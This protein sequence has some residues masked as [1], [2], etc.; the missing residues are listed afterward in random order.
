MTDPGSAPLTPDQAQA[1]LHSL[2]H[3]E[4]SWVDWGH[5]CR[6]LQQAGYGAEVIFEA[7]GFQKVQQNLVIVAAQVY[8]SLVQEGVNPEVLQYY[9]GPKSDVLYELRV[10]N[11]NQRAQTALV[12]HHHRL[13]AEE[14]KELAR[15][16]Q[17]LARLPQ[18]PAG[19]SSHPGDALAYQYWQRARQKKTLA[20]RAR[21]I[22]KGLKFAHSPNART[23][24]EA[25]LT[26]ITESPTLKAP[27]VPLYRIQE[28]E[29]AA[30]LIPIAGTLPLTP[31]AVIKVPTVLPQGLFGIVELK[32]TEPLSLAPLP[33]WQ[34][35]LKAQD[36]VVVLC[37]AQ[38]AA[39]TLIN[40]QEPVL[41]VVD[42]G[43]TQWNPQSYFL[44][45]HNDRVIIQWHSKSPQE[46][47]L[48]QV[49]VVLR[50]QKVLDENNLREPWQM[51]D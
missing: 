26:E 35:V 29:E 46:T 30:R 13:E 8:E 18:I 12:A 21:L 27:L 15:A 51:D 40:P 31:Q 28:D 2:L 36:P 32:I 38:E 45:A 42:R 9:L 6:Q 33:G 50:P 14:A 4:G 3:K 19:F 23:A 11:Q 20:D 25:L 5:Q 44:V 1:L 24:I 34:V 39:A 7:S 41:V 49:I 17:E 22:A 37:S 47:I 48:G 16:V 43:Q 10:L